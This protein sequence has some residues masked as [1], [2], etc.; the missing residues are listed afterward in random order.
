MAASKFHYYWKCTESGCSEI[1][2]KEKARI[3]QMKKQDM[4]QHNW[5]LKQKY[6][7]TPSVKMWWAVY[8][9]GEGIY[10]I[11]CKKHCC[12]SKLNEIF[13]HEP[14]TRFKTGAL[15]SHGESKVHKAAATT[16][17]TQRGSF[18]EK[19]VHEQNSCENEMFS[20]IFKWIYWL[21]KEDIAN[22]KISS[23]LSHLKDVGVENLQYFKHTSPATFRE[24]LITIGTEVEDEI[25]S[26]VGNESYGLLI[27]DVSDISGMEQMMIF[28]QYFDFQSGEV[29]C[30]FLSSTNLL[31][32]ADSANA[33]TLCAAVKEQL[34]ERQIPLKCLKGLST[35]GAAVMTGVKNGLGALLKED[36]PQLI[37]VHCICH[38]LALSCV[39]TCKDLHKIKQIEIE[40]TQLWRIFDNSPKKLALF[41]KVQIEIKKLQI[42]DNKQKKIARRLKKACQTRWLSFGNAVEAVV[43]DLPSVLQTLRQLKSTD[44]ACNGLFRKFTKAKHIGS[45]YIMDSV[46]PILNNLSRTF[47]AGSVNY[48]RIQPAID[49]CKG[50]LDSLVTSKSPIAKFKEAIKSPMLSDQVNATEETIRYLNKLLYDYVSILQ[51]NIDNRFKEAT[52]V[53]SAMQIFNPKSLP[54]K[55][56]TR[57]LQQ[58][59]EKHI[60]T[61]AQFYFKD[62]EADQNQLKSEWSNLKYDLLNLELPASVEN[63]ESSPVE[64]TIHHFCRNKSSYKKHFPRMLEVLTSLV[65]VPVSN[66]WPER[67]ASKLK[68]IKNRLRS[69]LKNDALNALLHMSING[70]PPHTQQ[71]KDLIGKCV[72]KWLGAKKGKSCPEFHKSMSPFQSLCLHPLQLHLQHNRKN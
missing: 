1:S 4:F 71:S 37:P 64:W 65:V 61:L 70:P 40:V 54:K 63:G 22:C 51:E 10:C 53:L 62:N 48:A 68:L 6:S 33:S 14:G 18:F 27:D 50:K 47:Q 8:V 38:R 23:L 34:L 57:D 67:G 5:L 19:Q 30:K 39:D 42:D 56:D 58:Y 59:G 7:F 52:P 11:L 24:M 55:K 32:N 44:A 9:E 72:Q 15:E 13:V 28:I 31:A 16:E 43:K 2:F 46:L 60:N 41:I 69:T 20:N 12:K 17:L 3:K 36:V 49:A 29:E 45:L 21:A 25:C 26:V 35:D 66:A